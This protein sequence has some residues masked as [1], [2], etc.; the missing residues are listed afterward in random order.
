MAAIKADMSRFQFGMCG[1]KVI[2]SRAQAQMSLP[3]AI[4]ARL[5]YGKVFLAELEDD[6]MVGPGNRRM[7]GPG[8]PFASTPR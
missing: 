7:A 3:Y 6:G 1:G 2:Q 4:A 5:R 8:F